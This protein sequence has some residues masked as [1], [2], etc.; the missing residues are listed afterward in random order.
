MS[1]ETPR[2]IY[3]QDLAMFR[4]RVKAFQTLWEGEEPPVSFPTFS[5]ALD[6]YDQAKHEE[7]LAAQARRPITGRADQ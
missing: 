6:V 1:D 4:A 3:R 2:A 5:A 7:Y